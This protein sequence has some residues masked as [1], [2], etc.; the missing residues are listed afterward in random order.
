MFCR[1]CAKELNDADAFCPACGLGTSAITPAQPAGM[2]SAIKIAIGVFLGILAFVYVVSF[3]QHVGE[4]F[5]LCF[6]L[7]VLAGLVAAGAFR[8]SPPK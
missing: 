5:F 4:V 7:A 8:K 3:Y 2:P 1:K 6:M